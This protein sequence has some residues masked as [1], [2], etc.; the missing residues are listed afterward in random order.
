MKIIAATFKRPSNAF[1]AEIQQYCKA[2]INASDVYRLYTLFDLQKLIDA[3]AASM[4]KER[5]CSTIEFLECEVHSYITFEVFN[6]IYD[7]DTVVISITTRKSPF[8]TAFN[9]YDMLRHVL[10][11]LR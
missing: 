8:E 2:L 4:S 9:D 11:P 3:K 6:L 7:N 1:I 10:L 5:R